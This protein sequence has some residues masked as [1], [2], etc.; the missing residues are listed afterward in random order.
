MTE[1]KLA[2]LTN[3]IVGMAMQGT[4]TDRGSLMLLTEGVHPT[5]E[6]QQAIAL[7]QIDFRLLK[8][9]K[10]EPVAIGKKIMSHRFSSP[11]PFRDLHPDHRVNQ[12]V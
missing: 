2:R 8:P 6:I 4:K 7:E 10:L 3:L 1:T 11:S 9:S 5:T 12:Q